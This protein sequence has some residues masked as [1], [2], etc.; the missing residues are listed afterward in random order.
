ME[1]STEPPVASPPVLPGVVRQVGYVVRDLDEAIAS[2]VALGVGPWF[3]IRGH[4][5]PGTYRGEPCEVT[6]SVAFANTGDLQLELIR[7]DDDTPSIYSEFLDSGREGYHQLA[8][9]AP[10]WEETMAAIDEAGWPVVW[11]GGDAGATRYVYVEVPGA[12]A[13]IVEVMELTELTTGMAT[14]VR[15]AAASWDGGDPVRN[16]M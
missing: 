2:W 16:L 6:L 7:Q 4:T 10:D 15:E 1:P 14:M 12:P 13:A 11:S 9:W 5:Q 3:V 8:W